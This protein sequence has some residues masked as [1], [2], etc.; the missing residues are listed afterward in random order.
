MHIGNNNICIDKPLQPSHC[1]T[2]DGLH[3]QI[4][5]HIFFF[6]WK[7]SCTILFPTLY[8]YYRFV[9]IYHYLS[10]SFWF[11]KKKKK[12]YML[13]CQKIR[14]LRSFPKEEKISTWTKISQRTNLLLLPRNS[15]FEKKKKRKEKGFRVSVS[16]LWCPNLLIATSFE[17][18]NKI[19]SASYIGQYLGHLRPLEP[20]ESFKDN[21]L[22]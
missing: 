18:Q 7:L 11:I 16:C 14:K 2:I 20:K 1:F 8:L 17:T 3:S 10:F 19:L 4:F 22:V 9:H 5:L 21:H 12:N 15:S 6:C 13:D